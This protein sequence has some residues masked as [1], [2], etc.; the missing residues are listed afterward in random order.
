MLVAGFSMGLG[1]IWRFAYLVGEY[2]GCAFVLLYLLLC[3]LISIPLFTMEISLGRKTQLNPVLG[4][5][6]I[7]K[8]GSPWVSF[9][10]LGVIV[11]FIILTYYIQIMGWIL[12]YLFKVPAGAFKDL[13]A[14][15]YATAF[16]DIT[17]NT[18][19]IA[20]ATLACAILIGLIS[21]RGLEK[22]IE[23]AT[24]FLMPALFIMLIILAIRSLT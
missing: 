9:G 15:G 12:V 5:R 24:T 8:K 23:K 17:A 1:N 18:G 7:M 16:S 10:W 6:A 11:A 21:I 3:L 14:E 4:M 19:L 22:G 20:S 2:G 13:N